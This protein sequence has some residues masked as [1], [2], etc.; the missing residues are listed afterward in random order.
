MNLSR[1]LKIGVFFIVLGTAGTVYVIMSTDGFN[2]FNTKVYEVL[3]DDATGL[4]TNSKVFMAGVPVGKIQSIDFDNGKALLKVAFLRDVQIRADATLARRS[5]SLLGNSMLMLTPGTELTPLVKEGGRIKS[6]PGVGDMSAVLGSAQGLSEQISSLIKEF[7]SRQMELLAVSLQTF[8]SIAQ[9]LDQRSNAELDRVTR[10]L[11]SSAQITERVNKILQDREGDVA[12]STVEVR[13]ALEN[14]RAA[15][16]EIRKGNGNI[17]KA[18]YDDQLYATLL[19]TV[20]KTD[21]AAQK[22]QTALDN[23]SHLATNAD[24]VVSDAGTIVSKASGLGVQVDT[25]TRYDFLASQFRAG[26]SLILEPQ[27]KDRWYRIGV[28]GAPNGVSSRTVTETSSGGTTTRTDTTT[29]SYG[30]AVDAELARRFGPF[31]LH[32]GLLESTAGL[33]LDY[34]VLNQLQVSGELFN[35]QANALPNLRGTLTYLPFFDPKSN[36]PWNWLYF[37]GGINDALNPNRDF[38]LG[39][40]LRFADEEVRGLVGLVPL[41]GK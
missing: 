17:G 24:K 21:E 36:K 29:T 5:S 26:A 4:T 28:S 16:D 8:N 27:S 40:G 9:K 20:Q 18:I 35:F 23:I 19:S 6:E 37:R 3:M 22:L 10:I 14:L 2:N 32:G 13:A 7:Q 11:E 39:A 34:Q 25:Q 15:T 38:F 41:A 1:Y 30:V 12:A 33:G 31:T